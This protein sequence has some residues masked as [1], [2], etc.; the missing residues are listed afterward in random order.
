ML[1]QCLV[2]GVGWCGLLGAGQWVPGSGPRDGALSEELATEPLLGPLLS[3]CWVVS[4]GQAFRLNP[5]TL[6]PTSFHRGLDSTSADGGCATPGSRTGPGASECT[7]NDPGGSY[8]GSGMG[9][10]NQRHVYTALL[11]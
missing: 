7:G 9:P 1:Y 6:L 5:S 3:G 8:R 4:Q 2:V 11:P 10:G